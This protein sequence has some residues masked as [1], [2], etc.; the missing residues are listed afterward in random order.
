MALNFAEIKDQTGFIETG[1][2]DEDFHFPI[3]AVQGF[4]FAIK[5]IESMGGGKWVTT[6]NSYMAIIHSWNCEDFLGDFASG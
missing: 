5:I 4:A 3:M 1:G 2:A 6:F